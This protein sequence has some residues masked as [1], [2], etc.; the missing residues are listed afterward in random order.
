MLIT[1]ELIYEDRRYHGVIFVGT[2]YENR[3][4]HAA[5]RAADSQAFKLDVSGSD[6]RFCFR[7]PYRECRVLRVFEG[8]VNLLSYVMLCIN[9]VNEPVEMMQSFLTL[10]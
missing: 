5:F 9:E 10:T 4:K 8:P 7:L 6:K 2:D 1:G 3:P